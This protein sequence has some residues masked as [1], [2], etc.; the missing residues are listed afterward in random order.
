MLSH[1]TN[2][3]VLKEAASNFSRLPCAIEISF[4][5]SIA[6]ICG[7]CCQA[8]RMCCADGKPLTS[9]VTS[10]VLDTARGSPAEGVTIVLER[11][12]AGS[13]DVWEGVSRGITNSDGRVPNLL[14]PSATI[15]P[16]IYR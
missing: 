2:G 7:K 8:E 1:M 4:F 11:K 16:G 10:H 13:S 14:E 12:A 9:P 6:E 5:S 3:V 15:E